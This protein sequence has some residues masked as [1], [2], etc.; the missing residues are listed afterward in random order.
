MSEV[1]TKSIEDRLNETIKYYELKRGLDTRKISDGSHTFEELYFHRMLLFSL[2]VN[3]N[4]KKAWK[5]RLHDDGTMFDGYFIVGITTS[6]GDY[7]YH[8]EDRY[9]NNFYCEEL[10]TAP[11]YDGHQPEDIVRL[12]FL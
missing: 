7:S 9:W 8:Y 5:S 11:P 2:V 12:F 6:M 10:P 3:N 4:H 1:Q